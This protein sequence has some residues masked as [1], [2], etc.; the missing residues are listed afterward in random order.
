MNNRSKKKESTES[1]DELHT[2]RVSELRKKTGWKEEGRW[3]IQGGYDCRSQRA[4]LVPNLGQRKQQESIPGRM[5]INWSGDCF[6]YLVDINNWSGWLVYSA[7]WRVD[8]FFFSFKRNLGSNF[9][10]TA[11]RH[12]HGMTC[13]GQ[14]ISCLDVCFC[15]E[16][17]LTYLQYLTVKY[18][19]THL[20]E[21]YL[22]CGCMWYGGTCIITYSLH[23]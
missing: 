17:N 21:S 20:I 23:W 14:Y 15:C 19:S 18:Y 16:I 11:V 1:G 8:S 4:F 9:I 7:P 12:S 6:T 2:A 22:P 10:F 3:W 13:M 5:C